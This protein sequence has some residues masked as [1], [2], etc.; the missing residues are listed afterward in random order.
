MTLA[1]LAQ[2]YASLLIIQYA[3]KDKAAGTIRAYAVPLVLPQ[4]SQQTLTFG[5]EV[6][7]GFFEMS[8]GV[9]PF[10]TIDFPDTAEEIQDKL[11][12]VPGF[13]NVLVTGSWESLQFLVTLVGIDIPADLLV[14]TD[15][16]L[17]GSGPFTPS[18]T[19]AEVDKT[20]PLAVNDAFNM[21][22]P[23]LAAGVNLDTLAKYIGVSRQATTPKGAITLSDADLY[24]L[25]QIAIV[26]NNSGSSLNAIQNLLWEFFEG[27]ITVQ[28][29]ADMN[30][31]YTLS[32][33]IVTPDLLN[34][35]LYQDLLPRPMAVG[36]GIIIYEITPFGFSELDEPEPEDVLGFSELV[37]ATSYDFV[38]SDGDFL[39][40]SDGDTLA[41][42]DEGSTTGTTGGGKFSELIEV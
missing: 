5:E 18:I 7:G 38:L 21:I 27:Q 8:Y 28:D 30:L 26:K 37:T 22:P 29:T 23:N 41:V 17:Q 24:T 34:M 3:K 14:I 15:N 19:I 31:I 20:L 39:E 13:E 11:R 12:T 40:L 42:E 6:G 36:V 16:Q 4:N 9:N 10:P 25:M 1:E 35:F 32:P 2:Y 33:D